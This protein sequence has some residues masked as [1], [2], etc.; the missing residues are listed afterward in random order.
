MNRVN[1]IDPFLK[2]A[3]REKYTILPTEITDR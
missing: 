1:C 2:K 3:E